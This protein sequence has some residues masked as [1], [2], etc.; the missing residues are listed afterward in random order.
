LSPLLFNIVTDMLAI[1]INRDKQDEQIAGVLPN[2]VDEGISILQ[3]ADGTIIFMDH[4]LNKVRNM[5]L[6]LCAFEQALGLK[7]NFYKSELFFFGQAQ[8]AVEQ[9]TSLFRCQE[10][11]FPLKYLGIPIHFRKLSNADWKR[12]EEQFEKKP[13]S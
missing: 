9:Y 13:S 6:L 8:E 11:D 2:L 10:G 4:D 3:Y 5:K 7:I 12:V 1:L